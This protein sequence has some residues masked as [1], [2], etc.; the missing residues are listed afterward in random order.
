MGRGRT[1]T[2]LIT[3]CLWCIHRGITTFQI[4]SNNPASPTDD[5]SVVTQVQLSRTGSAGPTTTATTTGVDQ[6]IT[7]PLA[8]ST[9]NAGAA[10]SSALPRVTLPISMHSKEED[11]EDEEQIRRLNLVPAVSGQHPQPSAHRPSLPSTSPPTSAGT[12]SPA[13]SPP[14]KPAVTAH[15][16][17]TLSIDTKERLSLTTPVP[18]TP[19]ALGAAT[20]S[21][22]ASFTAADAARNEQ[23]SKALLRGWYKVIQSLVR[24]LSDGVD[25]KKQVDRVIDH[26]AAFQNLRECVYETQAKVADALESKKEMLIK[27]YVPSRLTSIAA[28]LPHHNVALSLCRYDAAVPTTSSATSIS[29]YVFVSCSRFALIA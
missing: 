17:S 7:I 19:M 20:P 25:L 21:S 14:F 4:A 12:K 5:S 29:S 24:V 26:C 9:S 8:H 22:G 15:A 6:L 23:R 1:T 28:P 18:T 13:A 27:R 2:G 16:P 10:G 3:A 11:E